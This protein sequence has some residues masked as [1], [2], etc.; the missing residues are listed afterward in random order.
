LTD[1]QRDDNN[2]TRCWSITTTTTDNTHFTNPQQAT[3][4]SKYCRS[5]VG[6]YHSSHHPAMSSTSLLV[7]SSNNL[8]RSNSAQSQL[9]QS[10]SQSPASKLKNAA[11]S[12]L[13]P[14]KGATTPSGAHNASPAAS[15]PGRWQHPRMDEI[16]RRQNSSC[17]NPGDSRIVILNGATILFIF[18]V[19]PY[20]S[21]YVPSISPSSIRPS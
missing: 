13:T 15:T 8:V 5:R 3:Y 11:V 16:V 7:N 20:L 2:E 19:Q 21:A 12:A 1:R 6:Q 17:F 9:G 4:R 10:Q 14:Q 18:V